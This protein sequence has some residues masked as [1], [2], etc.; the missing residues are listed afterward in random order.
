MYVHAYVDARVYVCIYIRYCTPLMRR[1]IWLPESHTPA[2]LELGDELG[3]GHGGVRPPRGE[4]IGEDVALYLQEGACWASGVKPPV[5]FPRG[6]AALSA[7]DCLAL[8]VQA[9]PPARAPPL[10]LANRH[11]AKPPGASADGC[12]ARR[13]QA[14]GEAGWAAGGDT[15]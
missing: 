4:T 13:G 3:V 6:P 2:P 1:Y 9:P 11:G 8:V 7:P 12:R 15:A 5:A 14:T 10:P